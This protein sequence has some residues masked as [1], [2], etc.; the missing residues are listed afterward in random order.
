MFIMVSAKCIYGYCLSRTTMCDLNG[1]DV[2]DDNECNQ[3]EKFLKTINHVNGVA[4]MNHDFEFTSNVDNGEDG[5]LFGI[6]MSE[7]DA[8][9][10]GVMKI[11]EK[12]DECDRLL[13]VF[14]EHNPLF[15]NLKRNVYVFVSET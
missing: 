5:M 12:D 2:D 6:T 14:A 8:H 3:G 1:H 4:V 10:S 7:C 13:D 9:Y 11:V 15:K